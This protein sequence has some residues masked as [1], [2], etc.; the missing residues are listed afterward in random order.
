MTGLLTVVLF[1][2]IAGAILLIFLP[3]D[4]PG[5][6]KGGG[7]LFSILTF[8]ASLAIVGRFHD[9]IGGFQFVESHAWIPQWGINYTVG[10]DGISLWLVLLT[11]RSAPVSWN[12]PPTGGR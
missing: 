7:L 9:G 12:T 4:I 3:K 8:A 6:I 2:P 1:L 10:V 5:P 11:T